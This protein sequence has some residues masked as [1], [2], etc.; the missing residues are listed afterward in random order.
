VNLVRDLKG[1]IEREKAA[2]GAL[3][4]LRE[5]TAPM[6]TEAASAG[7]YQSENFSEK[8]PRLQILTIAELLAGKQLRCPRL[9]DDTVRAVASGKPG[10]KVSLKSLCLESRAAEEKRDQLIRSVPLS[11][12]ASLPRH[13]RNPTMATSRSKRDGFR[14]RCL[15]F[16]TLLRSQISE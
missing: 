8:C 12:A 4:T 6:L 11:V 15:L 2:I 3:L 16:C 14:R 13:K 1:V 9:R 7:F 5:P 10:G